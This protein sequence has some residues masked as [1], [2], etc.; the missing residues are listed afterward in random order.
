MDGGRRLVGKPLLSSG[1]EHGLYIKVGSRGEKQKMSSRYRQ[2]FNSR[3]L[4][5]N[6][7]CGWENEG[8]SDDSDF[9]SHAN[10]GAGGKFRTTLSTVVGQG[11]Q[12]YLH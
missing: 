6:W 3:G 4:K 5:S 10:A 12:R 7:K 9:S 1:R 11:R 8:L 2:K